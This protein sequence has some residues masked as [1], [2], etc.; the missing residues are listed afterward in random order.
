MSSHAASISAWCTVFDWPSIVA[1]TSVGRHGPASSS[2]A[3]RKI[4]GALLPGHARP[5]VP[6]FAGGVDRALDLRGAALVDGR[7]HAGP[8]REARPA[9]SVAGADVLA[10]D[11]H[12]EVHLL[13]AQL[14]DLADDRL[15]LGRAR[16]VVVNGL[17]DRRR[18]AE[19]PGA[20]HGG[21]GIGAPVARCVPYEAAGWG[22]G[23]ALARGRPAGLARAAAR[24]APG[25]SRRPP[26]DPA[27]RPLL[28][29]RGRRVRRR[30]ARLGGGD[31][32]R[33]RARRGARRGAARRGRHVRRA[34]RAGGPSAAPRGRPGPSARTTACR[35]SCPATALSPRAASAATGAWAPTTSGGCSRSRV[36]P[37]GER[38]QISPGACQSPMPR[39][40]RVGARSVILGFGRVCARP[41]SDS[42]PVRCHGPERGSTGGGGRPRSFPSDPPLPVCRAYAHRGIT[43]LVADSHEVAL[44]ARRGVS[45]AE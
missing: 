15:A 4:G 7:K 27:A 2:A 37:S 6:G 30:R 19:D 45:H 39:S 10:A 28:P 8:C 44:R 5:V 9:R 21:D 3:R 16:R 36:L 22:A 18:R 25:G 42:D 34:G 20:A 29:R 40:W 23:R 43:G 17:V 24:R 41:A 31:R 38:A 26:A 32:V 13:A 35:S 11:H 14:A 33:A 12:R 1:A